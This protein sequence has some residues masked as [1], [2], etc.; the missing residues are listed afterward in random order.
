MFSV[1]RNN[2]LS[3]TNLQGSIMVPHYNSK[4]TILAMV[5]EGT[6]RMEMACPHLSRQSQQKGRQEEESQS[7]QFER[8]TAQLSPGDIFI[9]PAGH[10]I[11]V[12]ASSNQNLRMVGFGV[13]ARN[14]ER[15]FIAGNLT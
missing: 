12:V 1:R 7:G 8:V 5:V 13:N 4:A 3:C 6:G 10:P 2:F 9:I 11:A 14:N 15:N